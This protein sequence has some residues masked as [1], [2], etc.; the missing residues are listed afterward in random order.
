MDYWGTKSY[1][2]HAFVIQRQSFPKKTATPN[3]VI[4]NSTHFTSKLWV[5]YLSKRHWIYHWKNDQ[6]G[7]SPRFI[8]FKIN[9][10]FTNARR[11]SRWVTHDPPYYRVCW[12][13][14]RRTFQSQTAP[15]ST[16]P[17]KPLQP[18]TFFSHALALVHL[19]NLDKIPHCCSIL[20]N[21]HPHSTVE[22]TR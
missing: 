19:L 6:T 1:R 22:A 8:S 18:G 10:Q 11:Q 14:V 17:I 16:E 2:S 21:G 20:W 3:G 7:P 4:H 5:T 15:F 12:H 9:R 13:E